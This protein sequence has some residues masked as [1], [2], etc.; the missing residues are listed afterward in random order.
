MMELLADEHTWLVIS[1]VAFLAVAWRFGKDAIL[2]VLD[3]RIAEIKKEIQTAETLRIEAQ[4]LLAQ[5]QRKHR[6]A[7]KDA[8]K[9]IADAKKGAEASRKEAEAALAQ[10]MERREAQLQERIKRMEQAAISEIQS[11]AADLAMK[12]ASKIVSDMLDKKTGD[13]LVEQS[14]KDLS[15]QIH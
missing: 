7:M 4:E 11:Y 6:D 3:G 2:K 1:F 12:A 10:S 15:T 13:K 14:I 8:E 5:Y 9:I